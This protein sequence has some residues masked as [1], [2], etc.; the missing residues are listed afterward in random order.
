MPPTD[1]RIDTEVGDI[2]SDDNNDLTGECD[3][4]MYSEE[5]HDGASTDNHVIS[6]TLPFV[7]P[8]DTQIVRVAKRVPG[9][10]FGGVHVILMGDFLQL[11]SCGLFTLVQRSSDAVETRESIRR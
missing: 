1:Q 6:Q 8:R 5:C 3:A 4:N 9:V 2:S 10:V 7:T 11:P